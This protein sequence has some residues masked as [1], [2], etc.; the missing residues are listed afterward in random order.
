MAEK[1]ASYIDDKEDLFNEVLE[2][3]DKQKRILIQLREVKQP[4]KNILYKKYIKGK[5]LATVANEMKYNYEH[6]KKMNGVALNIF[7]EEGEKK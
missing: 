6:I 7:D 4:Y 5:S 1:L 3:K 2:L